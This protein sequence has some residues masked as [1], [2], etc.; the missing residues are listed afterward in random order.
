MLFSDFFA[1]LALPFRALKLVLTTPRLF[2]LSAF[3]FALTLATLVALLVFVWPAAGWITEGW[4]HEGSWWRTALGGGLHLAVYLGL[5][6]IGLLTVPSVLLAPLQDPLSEATETK[7]GDFTAPPFS[8]ARL[9]SGTG[10]SLLH[11]FSR[12][13]LMLLGFGLLLPLNLIPAAG[14]VLYGVLSAAWSMWWVC[15]EYLSGPMA[16]HL[17]PF[18]AVLKAMRARPLYAMGMGATLYVVLWVPVLNCFLVPL[19]VVAG[20]LMFRAMPGPRPAGT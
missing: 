5:V 8:F 1:G 16:R 4:V 15:A 2:A 17:L 11:T 10:T 7:L 18:S 12:L 20:T 13:G 3:C 14:S 19:A 9:V 6:A